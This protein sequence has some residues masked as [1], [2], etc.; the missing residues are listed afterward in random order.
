MA[1]RAALATRHRLRAVGVGTGD[2]PE[3]AV[4]GLETR[5]AVRVRYV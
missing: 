3:A 1:D 2:V 5:V 4:Q